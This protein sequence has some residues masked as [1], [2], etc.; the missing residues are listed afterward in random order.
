[1]TVVE[2]YSYAIEENIGAPALAGEADSRRKTWK[3]WL[4]QGG[5]YALADAYAAGRWDSA[6]LYS[7]M[8]QIFL[9]PQYAAEARMPWGTVLRHALRNVLLNPQS[10]EGA[11]VVGRK[12]YDLGNDLFAAMLDSSMSYTCGIWEGAATLEQAQ[13]NKLETICRKLNLKPG[14]TVLDIGSGWGN[15]AHYAASHYGCRVTGVTVSTE[16]FELAARRCRGLPVEFILDDY[17]NVRG[18]FDHVVSIEM[19][20]A[21]GRKN[22]SRYFDLVQAC[23]RPGG[24]FLLQAI[25]AENF[26]SRSERR[27]DQFLLW[28][29]DNIFPNGFIPNL[30]EEVAAAG[31]GFRLDNLQNYAEDY[32]RTLLAWAENFER[33]WPELQSRYDEAFRRKWRFYLLS[34]AAVFQTGNVQ[35]YQLLYRKGGQ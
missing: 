12:H 17:R 3:S 30:R 23:L 26:S 34:C 10:G 8:R 22:L 35:L 27:Q 19:I 1:M 2:Q 14:D 11:F 32:T 21:V 29:L 6:D 5:V 25:T 15:F 9:D 16:Q 4:R 24:A 13:L 18:Q 7:D 20:E 28:I 31:V 33:N